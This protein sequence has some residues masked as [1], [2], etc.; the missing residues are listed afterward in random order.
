MDKK[1]VSNISY[2][3][4][5]HHHSII[6]IMTDSIVEIF[7]RHL[8]SVN[9]NT[10]VAFAQG[11]RAYHSVFKTQQA[12]SGMNYANTPD[13]LN[14]WNEIM[15]IRLDDDLWVH[16]P[17]FK[18]I[19]TLAINELFGTDITLFSPH[20]PLDFFYSMV[21]LDASYNGWIVSVL[22]SEVDPDKVRICARLPRFGMKVAIHVL[23]LTENELGASKTPSGQPLTLMVYDATATTTTTAAGSMI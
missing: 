9:S 6:I 17:H 18:R 14:S 7:S 10:A 12:C 20:C 5:C 16:T 4:V 13:Y 22:Q 23:K 19:V 8:P 2:Y 21:F 3:Y 15:V 11:M 1:R